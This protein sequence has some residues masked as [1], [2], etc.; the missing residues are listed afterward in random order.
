[1]K[2]WKAAGVD[3]ELRLK[4]YGAFISTTVFG[5]FDKMMLG[6]FPFYAEPDSYVA[7]RYLPGSPLNIY[8]INDPKLAQLIQEQR[9]TFDV[10]KRRALM[11]EIQRYAAEQAYFGVGG[12]TKVVSAWEAHVRNFGPNN[13]FDYGGRMMAAWLDR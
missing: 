2:N 8:N 4:E 11:F 9:R 1:V 6:L 5:K 7:P 13:G 10:A 12:S 3:A